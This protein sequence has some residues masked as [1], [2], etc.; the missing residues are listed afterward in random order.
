MKGI[1]PKMCI[2]CVRVKINKLFVLGSCFRTS[3][4]ILF[5]IFVRDKVTKQCP[6]TSTF[7]EKREPKQIRTEVPL[8]TSLTPYR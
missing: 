7:E 3:A 5:Q 6:Q 4:V 2:L 8:L 1:S